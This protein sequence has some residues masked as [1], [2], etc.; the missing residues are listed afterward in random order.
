MM[1]GVILNVYP[2][3]KLEQMIK[4]IKILLILGSSAMIVR[5]ITRSSISILSQNMT[6]K[7]RKEAYSN[8]THQPIKYFDCKKNSTGMLT[9]TLSADM[10]AINGAAVENYVC[11]FQSFVGLIASVVVAFIYNTK[12]GIVNLCFVPISLL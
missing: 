12:I 8:I 11:V 3:Y 10:K 2:K 5:W 6:I 4:Y 7:I 1:F 9:S